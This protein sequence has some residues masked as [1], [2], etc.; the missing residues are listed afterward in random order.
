MLFLIGCKKNTGYG[1][2]YH[3]SR[4]EPGI[5]VK[6]AVRDQG[7]ICLLYTSFFVIFSYKNSVS[8]VDAM[9]TATISSARIP[10]FLSLIHILQAEEVLKPQFAGKKAE[11]YVYTKGGASADNEIDAITSATITTNAVTN[12]VNAGLYYFCLLYT[13]R[14]V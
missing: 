3:Y 8:T 11:S 6:S 1:Q 4:Q 2:Q 10:K 12:G 14:C 13:S 5:P 9:V 7:N